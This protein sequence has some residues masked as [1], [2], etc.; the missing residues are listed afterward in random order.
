MARS[1]AEGWAAN[2]QELLHP[3]DISNKYINIITSDGYLGIIIFY[4]LISV[5]ASAPKIQY[6]SGS[7]VDYVY[8]THFDSEDLKIS[9]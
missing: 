7:C 4:F 6:L 9:Q 1:I 8:T 5:L 3:Q 2:P